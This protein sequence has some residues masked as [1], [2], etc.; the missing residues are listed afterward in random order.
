MIKCLEDQSLVV[1]HVV[2]TKIQKE[3]ILVEMSNNNLISVICVDLLFI[4]SGCLLQCSVCSGLYSVQ[5]KYFSPIQNTIK[6]YA[7]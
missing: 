2:L 1:E 5:S 7:S 4:F 6:S 3:V